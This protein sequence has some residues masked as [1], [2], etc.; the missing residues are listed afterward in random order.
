MKK[1]MMILILALSYKASAQVTSDTPV[2]SPNEA[3]TS[4]EHSD[5]TIAVKPSDFLPI[6]LS[7]DERKILAKKGYTVQDQTLAQLTAGINPLADTTGLQ[8][9]QHYLSWELS[10]S[11]SI[12]GKS[13]SMRQYGFGTNIFPGIRVD[14]FVI[15]VSDKKA[16]KLQ[17]RA[18]EALPACVIKAAQP[19]Q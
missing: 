10:G 17:R 7:N 1:L 2:I 15:E 3:P 18:I 9:T 14:Y 8:M 11:S 16:D 4:M 5:C 6:T 13:A 12:N 19:Q